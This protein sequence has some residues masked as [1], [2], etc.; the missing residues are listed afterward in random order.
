MKE[1][2]PMKGV[3]VGE[4]T[5][6]LITRRREIFAPEPD[7]ETIN[8]SKKSKPLY[9]GGAQ[10]NFDMHD[11]TCK[12]YVPKGEIVYVMIG[13]ALEKKNGVVLDPC[14]QCTD[15]IEHTIRFT[16]YPGKRIMIRGSGQFSETL[17][18]YRYTPDALVLPDPG[19]DPLNHIW[20]SILWICGRRGK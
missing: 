16:D 19:V 20:Y 14:I 6:G 12:I 9:I 18:W 3:L 17:V 4:Y 1:I 13:E 5:R 7:A 11:G 10:V 8:F 15:R 2:M